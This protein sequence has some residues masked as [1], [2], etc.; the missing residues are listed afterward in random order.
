MRRVGDTEWRWFGSQRDAA[1]AFGLG[2]GDVSLLI[3]DPAKTSSSEEFEARPGPPRERELPTKRKAAAPK[4]PRRVEGAEQK[5]N[6]KWRNH[7]LFPGRVFDD[8]DEYRAAKKQ[9]AARRDEY[10]AQRYFW[11]H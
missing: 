1:N 5:A 4:K 11:G 3:R 10:R 2:D 6:G 9:R 8:I 7:K